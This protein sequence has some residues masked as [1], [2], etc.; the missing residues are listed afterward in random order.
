[1]RKGSSAI[2]NKALRLGT[3]TDNGVEGGR[4]R[5]GCKPTRR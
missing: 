2:A 5:R 3:H 1:M 4:P